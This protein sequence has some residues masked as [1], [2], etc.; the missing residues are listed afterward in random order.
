MKLYKFYFTGGICWRFVL[1]A[2]RAL[3]AFLG[4]P[5]GEG[6]TGCGQAAR[7]GP[8]LL[9]EAVSLSFA[10]CVVCVFCTNIVAIWNSGTRRSLRRFELEWTMRI[11]LVDGVTLLGYSHILSKFAVD[12]II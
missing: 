4:L 3:V 1:R 5:P 6:R 12:T 2:T 7:H 10:S 11:F 8:V 9:F